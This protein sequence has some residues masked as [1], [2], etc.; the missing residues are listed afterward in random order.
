VFWLGQD[1][2]VRLETVL[3]QQ[4]LIAEPLNV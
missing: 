1:G 4:C 3:L 2:I